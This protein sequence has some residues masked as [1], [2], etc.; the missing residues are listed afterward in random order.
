MPEHHM[1]LLRW[2]LICL[3]LISAMPVMAQESAESLVKKAIQAAGYPMDGKPYHQTWREQGK[4]TM[5]GQELPYDCSW[6]F[7]PA[8]KFRFD[9]KAEVQGQ[10]MEIQFIQNGDKAKETAMGVT[11]LLKG[12]KLEETTHSAYQ[13][14]VNS[15]TPLIVEKGFT[16]KLAG[17]REF[18]GRKVS[19]V[20]V[21]REGRRDITLH[22]DQKTNLL[23]GCSDQVKDE[24]QGW[25]LV[26]QESEFYDYEKA[27]SGEMVFKRMIVKRDGQVLLQSK[28]SDSKRQSELK[29]ELFKID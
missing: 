2:N 9:M 8:S 3:L 23:A 16:L 17:E 4:M 21:S 10:K 5:A 22:F 28:F 13:F 24:F 1:K 6:A 29:P 7:E 12:E 19:S 27:A 11:Q 25:K 15:L 18:A 20:L 14:W 26:N